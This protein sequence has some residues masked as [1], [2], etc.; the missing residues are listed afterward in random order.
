MKYKIG[1]EDTEEVGDISQVLIDSLN[2]EEDGLG[3][4]LAP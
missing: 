1:P 4:R 3:D 2:G